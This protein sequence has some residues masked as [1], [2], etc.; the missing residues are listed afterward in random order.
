[1]ITFADD[2]DRV[3]PVS[4]YPYERFLDLIGEDTCVL[5]AHLGTDP[6]RPL[7]PYL[8]SWAPDGLDEFL[9]DGADS[10][11]Y[12][13]LLDDLYHLDTM[14]AAGEEELLALQDVFFLFW[15]TL[16]RKREY[17]RRILNLHAGSGCRAASVKTLERSSSRAA[18][19]NR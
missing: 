6:D 5:P 3:N 16:G 4:L 17:L 19:T 13:S 14:S 18:L 7:M 11:H 15:K 8:P 2:G 1:M 12:L 10:A 9:R